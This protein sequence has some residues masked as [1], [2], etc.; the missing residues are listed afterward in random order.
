MLWVLFSFQLLINLRPHVFN[1]YNITKTA[2][3]I[4]ITTHAIFRISFKKNLAC[5]YNKIIVCT[6]TRK[7]SCW[8]FSQLNFIKIHQEVS[9]LSL[10]SLNYI[11]QLLIVGLGLTFLKWVRDQRNQTLSSQTLTEKTRPSCNQYFFNV[12]KFLHAYLHIW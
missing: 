11:T 6:P 7:T 1:I 3:A 4:M 10:E 8:S 12:L 2:L 5:E 9:L